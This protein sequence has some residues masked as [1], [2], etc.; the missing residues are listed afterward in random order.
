MKCIYCDNTTDEPHFTSDCCGRGM[1]DDCYNGY[2]G[3]MEQVH[4]DFLDEIDTVKKKYQ[5]ATYLCFECAHIWRR[6]VV[7]RTLARLGFI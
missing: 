3:T 7:A 1:C 6:G 2:V 5:K 4:I